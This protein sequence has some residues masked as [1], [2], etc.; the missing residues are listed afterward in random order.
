MAGFH[1]RHPWQTIPEM[2]L[3]SI[4]YLLQLSLV[5]AQPAQLQFQDCFAGSTT[6]QKLDISTI[7]AQLFEI[8]HG[9]LLNFTI[10]GSTPDTIQE[11]SN[12]SNP[13]ASE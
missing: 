1:A 6:S 10:L 11:A 8:P 12:G 9:A 3:I 2:L 5:Y 13:V 7:Y 4:L